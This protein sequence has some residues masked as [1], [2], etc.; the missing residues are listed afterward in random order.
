MHAQVFS[1]LV[2]AA[3]LFFLLY[4][5]EDDVLLLNQSA[6]DEYIHS[7]EY[8]VDNSAATILAMI[9]LK[10]PPSTGGGSGNAAPGSLWYCCNWW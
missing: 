10:A 5:S 4:H 6:F 7:E 9:S 2:Q 1:P 8:A 3:Q